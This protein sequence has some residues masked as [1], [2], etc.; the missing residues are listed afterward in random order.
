MEMIDSA[1]AILNLWADMDLDR[2]AD[3]RDE[4]MHRRVE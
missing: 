1:T 4:P 2:L 3:R